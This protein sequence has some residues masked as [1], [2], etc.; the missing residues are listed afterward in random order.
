MTFRAKHLL[1]I[2]PLHPTEITTL[3]DLADSYADHNRRGVAH[4]DVL[5]GL[6]A[7]ATARRSETTAQVA[8]ITGSVGKTSAKEMLRA[9]LAPQGAVHAAEKS[10]NNHWGVPLTLARCPLNAEFAVIEIGMNH[11]DEIRP[12]SK[13]ARPHA[14]MITT[15]AAVHL[16]NFANEA[17]IAFADRKSTRLNSSHVR[18]SRMPSSA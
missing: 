4:R 11:A 7:M 2:E 16:E 9:A 10:F 17:G 18:T 1:G 5:A 13:L 8:A 14:A 12:L 15:V 3:L 6:T